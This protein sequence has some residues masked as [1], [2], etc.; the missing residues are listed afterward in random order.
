M[1]MI[2]TAPAYGLGHSESIV[3]K[4]LAG[5]RDKAVVAT[6]C[7]LVWYAQKGTHFFDEAGKPVYRY[8]GGDSIRYEVEQSLKRLQTDYIDLLQTHWQDAT[9]PLEETM[10]TLLDLKKEGKI[11]AI[12]A[13]NCSVSDLEHYVHLGQLDVDQEKFSMI[14]RDI[15]TEILPYVRGNDIALLAYAP[16]SSGLLTGKVPPGRVFPRDDQRFDRP[17]FSAESRAKIMT[18]LNKMKPVADR[19]GL[20]LSQLVI[21]W[22]IAQP[23][24]THALVGA[25]DE[26]Q[27]TENARAGSVT[28]TPDELQFVTDCISYTR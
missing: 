23:G 19:H 1:N 10:G 18:M 2:D 15:E 11:R 13:S 3:G 22:T 9:T 5:R 20:T 25:R 21:A 12:G 28:L 26:Q 14:D 16:L 8:L 7:G 4:A 6:K 27:A 17:R 24:V